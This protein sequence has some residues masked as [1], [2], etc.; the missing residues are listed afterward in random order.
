MFVAPAIGIIYAKAYLGDA[1]GLPAAVKEKSLEIIER[2][3]AVYARMKKRGIRILPGGDY[4]FPWNPI[5]QN[6]RDLE[7]FVKLFGWQPR[8]VL[9]AATVGGAELLDQ[10]HQLG[11]IREGFLAD[12]LLVRDDPLQH[13]ERLVAADNIVAVMQDGRFHKAPAAWQ[14]VARAAQPVPL[15]VAV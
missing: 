9:K 13:I 10:A 2:N 1:F 14:P 8:E 12:L 3:V 4:G 6:A 5:G 7:L 11:R 15:S